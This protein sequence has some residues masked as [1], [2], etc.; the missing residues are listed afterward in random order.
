MFVYIKTATINQF[1][2]LLKNFF[3]SSNQAFHLS[4]YQG[5]QGCN[6]VLT[7]FFFMFLRHRLLLFSSATMSKYLTEKEKRRNFDAFNHLFY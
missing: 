2:F 3:F 5:R 1:I 6:A 4:F 7:L